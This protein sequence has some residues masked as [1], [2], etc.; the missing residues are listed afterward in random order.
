MPLTWTDNEFQKDSEAKDTYPIQYINGVYTFTI[1]GQRY[2][3]TANTRIV[4]KDRGF[5]AGRRK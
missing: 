5:V 2:Y 4:R 3:I 1:E